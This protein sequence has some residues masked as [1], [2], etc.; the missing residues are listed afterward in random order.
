MSQAIPRPLRLLLGV[1]NVAAR[2]E[3]SPRQLRQSVALLS[4][5][6]DRLLTR[7]PERAISYE[8]R[9]FRAPAGHQL[10]ARVYRPR[11]ASEVLRPVVVYYHGGGFMVGAPAHRDTFY[12]TLCDLSDCVVVCPSYRL[13]PEHPFPAATED[14]YDALCWA[15]AQAGTFGGDATRLAV[16]GESAGGNLATLVSLRARDEGGPKVR[17]QA[18]L[19]PVVDFTMGEASIQENGEGYMLTE[20]VIRSF[21]EAYLPPGH[22]QRDPRCSPRFARL[23]GLPPALIITA[24][25]DPLRDEGDRYAALL[26][27][28][29]VAV[30]HHRYEGMIHDFITLMSRVLPESDEAL[31]R[32]ATSLRD[33]LHG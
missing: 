22:D 29:G 4:R 21:R 27:G 14:A 9:V 25:Y 32:V 7:G 16:A 6:T 8:E 11:E 5:L 12:R 24:Q 31:R 17:F 2:R 10:S 28:A 18:L 3:Q 13:A 26:Q 30:A 1:I 33:A 23:E 20:A 19:Y 15:H